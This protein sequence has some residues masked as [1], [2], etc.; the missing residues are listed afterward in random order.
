MFLLL[1]KKQTVACTHPACLLPAS[2]ACLC[3]TESLRT[4]AKTHTLEPTAC[5]WVNSASSQAPVHSNLCHS[6]LTERPEHMKPNCA[7]RANGE[8]I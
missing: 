2:P 7:Q 5:V 3:H 6:D 8:I 4:L 1:K